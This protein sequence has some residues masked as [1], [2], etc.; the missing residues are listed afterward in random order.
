LKGI[1]NTYDLVRRNRFANFCVIQLRFLIGIGF[2][3]SGIR[4][5]INTP[6]ALPG[7]EGA[8]FEY[9]DALYATGPYYQMLGW[10]QIIAAILIISQRFATLGALLFLPIIFNIMVLTLSTIGSLT[11][12]IA[13]LMFLGMLF[14]VLWDYYKWINIFSHDNRLI[15]I[16]SNNDYPS[17]SKWWI[18]TGMLILILP[19]LVGI[20]QFFFFSDQFFFS[21]IGPGMILLSLLIPFISFIVKGVVNKKAK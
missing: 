7:Q 20:A 3:P 13:S 15:A 16:P 10:A 4:K 17:P 19:A 21:Y 12:I 5:V 14:L 2:L 8:F 18:T 11:P 1:L 6:F 9:L